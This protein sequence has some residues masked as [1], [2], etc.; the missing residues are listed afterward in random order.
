MQ[1]QEYEWT[2]KDSR[3]LFGQSWSPEKEG[4]ITI[5]MVHGLGE[6]SGRYQRWAELFVEKSYNF[7]S[8]D[9]RGHGRSEG[10]R[11]HARTFERML[12]DIDVLIRESAKI[13]P[14]SKLVMYGHSMGGNLALNHVIMRNYPLDALIVTSPWLRLTRPPSDPVLVMAGILNRVIPSLQ[15]P[16]GLNPDD[17]SHDPEVVRHYTKDPLNHNRIS[18]KL[19]FELYNGGYH[20]LRN[21][22]K[23]NCPFL[24]MHGT[25][26]NITSHKASET[27]VLNTNNRT[28]LKLWEGQYHELHNELIYKDVFQYIINWLSGYKLIPVQ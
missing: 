27:Y 23:I 12:D 18:L 4:D 24:I 21:V 19:F 11:G 25:G 13:F 22:Y 14:G 2:S 28:H 6:H 3:K 7:I 1:H 26:D 17:I 5:M 16:N 20:A 10:K 9:F 15:I 8:V